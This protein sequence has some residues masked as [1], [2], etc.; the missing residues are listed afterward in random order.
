MSG[1]PFWR[2]DFARFDF[3]KLSLQQNWINGSGERLRML[4]PEAQLRLDRRSGEGLPRGGLR[5]DFSLSFPVQTDGNGRWMLAKAGGR[6]YHALGDWLLAAP[7]LGYGHS[8][9]FQQSVPK[10][11]RQYTGGAGSVRGYKLDSIGP[12]GVDGLATGGLHAGYAGLDLVIAPAKRFSPVLSY[13]IGKVWG[14]TTG[15][16]PVAISIGVGLI[17]GTPAGPVRLDIFKPLRRRAQDAG[18]Q[19]YFSLGEVL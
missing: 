13:D 1:G 11:L 16:E 15:R 12:V 7:R 10:A 4:V 19:F 14:A 2:H 6:S 18:F 5:L 3:V 8:L 17:V 9:S